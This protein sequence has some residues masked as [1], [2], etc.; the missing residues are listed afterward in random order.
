MPRIA[1]VGVGSVGTFF[2]AHLAAAGHDVLAC[3]RRPFDTYRVESAEAP[4]TGPANVA[5]GPAAVT[6]G[7]YPW[8]LV[9][10][11]AHQTVDA[12]PWFDRLCGPDSPGRP[13][14]IVVAVQNGVEAVE[15]FTPLV[16]GATV[17]PAVVYCGAELQEPG[18]I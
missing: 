1:V 10:V 18:R 9:A 7:P 3:A 5:T 4:V 17:V 11:K 6:G 12:A 8:L 2:A 14:S 13:A 15:R 16:H